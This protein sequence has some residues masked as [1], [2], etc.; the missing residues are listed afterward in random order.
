MRVRVC[1]DGWGLRGG[2]GG[3]VFLYITGR[4]DMS[5]AIGQIRI[6]EC[7]PAVDVRRFGQ[8]GRSHRRTHHRYKKPDV[9]REATKLANRRNRRHPNEVDKGGAQL[10]LPH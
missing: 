1:A 7:H 6:P 10:R 3:G 9:D 4:E 2:F 5:P 8:T